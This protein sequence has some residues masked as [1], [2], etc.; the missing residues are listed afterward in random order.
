MKLKKSW[1]WAA[2]LIVLAAVIALVA[3]NADTPKGGRDAPGADLEA[4]ADASASPELPE[5]N[6]PEDSA[7]EQPG[8]AQVRIDFSVRNDPPLLKK[9]AQYNS[10]IPPIENY[11]R[12]L[13]H[14][15]SVNAHSFRLDVGMG[16]RGF[17]GENVV[18]GSIDQP[19]YD[20]E[21]VDR[22][23][24]M[25]NELDV[26]PYYSWAYVPKPLQRDGDFRRLNDD[27]VPD[28][29]EKWGDMLK[30]IAKHYVDEGIRIG[31]HEIYN[32]P[33]LQDVFFQ[34]PF[35]KYLELYRHGSRAIREADPDAMIGGPALAGAD[36]RTV[37]MD[38]L[39][40]VDEEDLPLDFFSF[41][42]YW[43]NS[44]FWIKVDTIRQVLSWY[45]RF[46]TTEIHLNELSYV[47][48]WQGKDSLNNFYGIAPKMFDVF[49]EVLKAGDITL[50]HWAQFMESTFQ[51]DAYGIIHRDG[52]KKAA[53]NVFQIYADMPEERVAVDWG[54]DW[55]AGKK[56]GVLAS[57]NGNKASVVLWNR[58]DEE[59][60]VSAL[61]EELPFSE[62]NVRRYR[63]DENHA[64]VL[65]GAPEDLT[66]E[67]E[68]RTEGGEY[69]W[70]G[71]LPAY[72]V[73]YISLNETGSDEGD[74]RPEKDYHFT[75]NDIRTHYYF[76]DRSKDNYSYFDRKKWKFFLGTGNQETARSLVGVTAE[77][78]PDTLYVTTVIDGEIQAV[79]EHTAL[80]MRVDYETAS[81]FVKSVVF[82]DGRYPGQQE[83]SYPFGTLRAA[84]EV[85]KVDSLE[86]FR[87]SLKEYAPSGWDDGRVLISFDMRDTGMQT[88][89][90]ATLR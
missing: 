38:F 18:S 58:T 41:H 14:L 47:A 79:S 69:R 37:V 15:R 46:K 6:D 81:G 31:F 84:D 87:V 78:L 83:E 23:A 52:R 42:H 21:Q 74:F 73:V 40:M 65:D 29:P 43:E 76:E 11:E 64:S 89:L 19:E 1:A 26:L 61:L 12:D 80:Y 17:I 35:S 33:D 82:H 5:P 3:W 7:A 60:F 28:W 54:E 53:Y 39:K 63:I 24:N 34:E 13:D 32:E 27:A 67:G 57:G 86:E 88:R 30:T 9:I 77:Q 49:E 2:G 45:D 90:E 66:V 4:S 22:L 16:S 71:V 70:E 48:N 55:E 50:A 8:Y 25:L 20:F 10:G 68:E 62:G 75:G 59:Q 72:G 36:K 56:I 51:D 85:V 44:P